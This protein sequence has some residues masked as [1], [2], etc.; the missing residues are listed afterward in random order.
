MQHS[1]ILTI[2]SDCRN[3]YKSPSFI[4]IMTTELSEIKRMRK[5]LGINQTQLAKQAGVSQSLI[6]KIE[7]G[8]IDPTYTKAQ[9][10]LNT[11]YSLN[12]HNSSKVDEIMSKKLI[13]LSPK[14]LV[15]GAINK[16]KRYE[17]S[18]L[19]VMQ[20]THVVGMVAERDLLDAILE[21]KE[22]VEEI[23]EQAPP[24]ISADTPV[25]TVAQ[26]LKFCPIVLIQDKGKITGVVTKA[27]VLRKTF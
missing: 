7:T 9:K 10:I 24:I 21:K 17:I 19:P 13:T 27:D 12:Q 5:Q 18:Q 20:G 1:I 14:D 2:L 15:K 26:L 25:P 22:T 8:K 23:M 6:A 11:I 3:E 16:M 4:P